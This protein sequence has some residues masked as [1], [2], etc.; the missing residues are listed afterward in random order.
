MAQR[1]LAGSGAE[2][3]ALVAP[4]GNLTVLHAAAIGRSAG[5]IPQLA[6]ACAEAGILVDAQL[7]IEEEFLWSGPRGSAMWRQLRSLGCKSY[8]SLGEVGNRATALS[9]AVR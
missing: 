7:Q 4:V 5:A 1:L 3:L 2:Q 8:V 9:I 6:A